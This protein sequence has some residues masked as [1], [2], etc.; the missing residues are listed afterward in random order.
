MPI[1]I[2]DGCR[3][4]FVKATG[5]PSLT[6]RASS[7]GTGPCPTFP[8]LSEKALPRTTQSIW[9]LPAGHTTRNAIPES[10]GTDIGS[11]QRDG[12]FYA[13]LLEKLKL[14]APV[15]ADDTPADEEA[16]AVVERMKI[17]GFRAPTYQRTRAGRPRPGA[18]AL[19]GSHE[20]ALRPAS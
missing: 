6:R 13:N 3:T 1:S 15:S 5:L 9:A 2:S 12:F 18:F 10:A 16:D 11:V 4:N 8:G 19:G 17:I 14:A 7:P 20:V